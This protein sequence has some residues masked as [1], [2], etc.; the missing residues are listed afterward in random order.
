VIN[1]PLAV[2]YL[3]N[4][5]LLSGFE[6]YGTI[7]T[8]GVARGQ[9]IVDDHHFWHHAPNVR[10]ATKVAVTDFWQLFLPRVTGAESPD[11]EQILQQLM[12]GTSA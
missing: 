2:A 8:D 11:L 10:I 9:S 6:S 3:I 5:S 7:A 12:G 4:P 1:D